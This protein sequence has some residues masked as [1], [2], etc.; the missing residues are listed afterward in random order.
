MILLILL[1]SIK[2][3]DKRKGIIGSLGDPGHDRLTLYLRRP[4][5]VGNS[6]TP[7]ETSPAPQ[8]TSP[9]EPPSVPAR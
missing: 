6:P 5:E 4:S 9:S 8:P 3:E 2:E 7:K 1:Q